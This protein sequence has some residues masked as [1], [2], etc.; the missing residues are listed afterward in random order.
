V[1]T[2]VKVN[3]RTNNF[4]LYIGRA[5]AGFP[6]SKWANP[7]WI[8]SGSPRETV[9]AC[10]EDYVRALPE[11]MD[12][13][14]EIDD[15]TLGCWCHPQPCHGDVLIKLRKEQLDSLHGRS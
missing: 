2:V 9:L 6:R 12:A 15:Q 3:Q 4:T 8:T 11:L 13:L 14:H 1:T 5:F 7:Y 10:Y